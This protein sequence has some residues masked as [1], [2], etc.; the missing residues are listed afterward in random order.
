[1]K[2]G[3]LRPA[4]RLRRYMVLVS[5][6]V[7][8]PALPSWVMKKWNSGRPLILFFSSRWVVSHVRQKENASNFFV[9][10][11]LPAFIFGALCYCREY[12]P[13]SR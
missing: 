11:K 9:E 8:L 1:V 5:A 12:H 10:N 7:P 13:S 6:V 3:T 4:F 2:R